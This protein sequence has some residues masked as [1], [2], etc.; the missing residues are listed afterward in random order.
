MT[1]FIWY[2]T[3]EISILKAY[4]LTPQSWRRFHLC[5]N[6]AMMV[7]LHIYI[8]HIHPIYMFSKCQCFIHIF[9]SFAFHILCPLNC[10][11]C[12]TEW[13]LLLVYWTYNFVCSLC[14]WRLIRLNT[15]PL[16]HTEIIIDILWI[17]DIEKWLFFIGACVLAWAQR[18][19]ESSARI[20][21]ALCSQ[22]VLHVHVSPRC[23]R[24][25]GCQNTTPASVTPSWT[26]APNVTD[27]PARRRTRRDPRIASA[28]V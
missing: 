11:N 5:I 21:G 4:P 3:N 17:D 7:V 14:G 18:N 24:L 10:I 8:R 13:Y 12:Q 20:S 15:P 26:R 22:V 27:V 6:P 16:N 25:R 23:I 19:P 1:A 28:R 9:L 2:Q